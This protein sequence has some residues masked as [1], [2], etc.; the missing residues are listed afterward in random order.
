MLA[1]GDSPE[2]L[3]EARSGF[4]SVQEMVGA[5][6]GGAPDSLLQELRLR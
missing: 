3:L 4:A 5:I 2:R 1:A 6:S